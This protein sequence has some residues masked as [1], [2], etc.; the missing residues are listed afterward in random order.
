MKQN[1]I[2]S[3][4]IILIFCLIFSLLY[5]YLIVDNFKIWLGI[6]PYNGAKVG[7][8]VIISAVVIAP[9]VEEILFR[10]GLRK[11]NSAI[12]FQFMPIIINFIVF[13]YY[14]KNLILI[15]FII[16]SYAVFLFI[17]NIKNLELVYENNKIFWWIINCLIFSLCH[18]FYLDDES[19]NSYQKILILFI[20][21]V[22]VSIC[23]IYLRVNFGILHAILLHSLDNLFTLILNHILY[24]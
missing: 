15:P 2:K 1:I 8:G 18:T 5:G 21:Y 6:S 4:F 13:Y 16:F 22:P 12:I 20:T 10:F 3:P 23:L 19:I 11:N 24:H 17:R 7:F 9:I 14:F